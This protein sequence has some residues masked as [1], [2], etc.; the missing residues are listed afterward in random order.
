M[1]GGGS[2]TETIEKKG[3]PIKISLAKPRR[4]PRKAKKP[5]L[6]KPSG[7]LR[8]RKHKKEN[9]KKVSSFLPVFQTPAFEKVAIGEK[10]L[11]IVEVASSGSVKKAIRRN[12]LEIKK[13]EAIEQDKRLLQEEEWEVPAF[14][15]R[16]KPSTK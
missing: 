16:V 15:R 10:K 4:K 2:K 6:K 5:E 9:E 8:I 7:K 1:A 14:L 12:A 11:S 13:A 3:E